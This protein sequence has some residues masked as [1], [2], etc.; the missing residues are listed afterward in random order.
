MPEKDEITTFESYLINEEEKEVIQISQQDYRGVFKQGTIKEV[1]GS[2]NNR[3][4]Y[5][6]NLVESKHDE[7][8]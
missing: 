5:L 1:K 6:Q 3:F 2:L 4:I 7:S 8:K